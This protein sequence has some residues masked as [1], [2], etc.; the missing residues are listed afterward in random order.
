MKNAWHLFLFSFVGLSLTIHAQE[1]PDP[2]AARFKFEHDTVNY[3]TI[4]YNSDGNRV[5]KFTNAGKEPLIISQAKGSC[6]CT[7]PTA[8]KEPIM[9]G[10]SG[11]IKVHYATDRVGRISKS[12]TI[13]SN[14]VPHSKVIFIVGNV[15]PGDNSKS[16]KPATM[17][18]LPTHV[19][20]TPPSGLQRATPLPNPAK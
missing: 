9:P 4:A 1:N 20:L 19:A 10:Q 17:K 18:A 12:I 11:E 5:F 3:G 13:T 16:P 7:I 15:L 6:G 2:D 8:P 14:A